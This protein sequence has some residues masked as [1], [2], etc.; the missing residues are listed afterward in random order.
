ML[1]IET[2][3]CREDNHGSRRT[4]PVSYLVVHYTAGNGDTARDNGRYFARCAVGAS[5]HYF[6]D[7]KQVVA[8]VAEENVAWH[9]GAASY[10]HPRCRNGNSI[11]VELCSVLRDGQY[12]FEAETVENAL[13]LL[14]ELMRRYE[15]PVERVLRHYDVTGKVCPAPFVADTA[16]WQQFL[17]RLE[18]KTMTEEAFAAQMAQYLKAL[19]QEPPAEWS[20]EARAWAE[21]AGIL[22]GDGTGMRYRSP[23]TREE[24]VQVLYRLEKG[25]SHGTAE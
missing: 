3:P 5:A 2:I 7:S 6:V 24:L 21:G 11:G 20:E 14:A 8:S 25:E 22:Q 23:L 10:R 15:I 9:C 18:E 12:A 4:E 17:D 16:A 13:A 1:E 19:A